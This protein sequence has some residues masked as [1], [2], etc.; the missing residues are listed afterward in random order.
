[1]PGSTL[2]S[3]CQLSPKSDAS[4]LSIRQS[5]QLQRQSSRWLNLSTTLW[6]ISIRGISCSD[7]D[8]YLS[9]LSSF[10]DVMEWKMTGKVND[11]EFTFLYSEWKKH[12]YPQLGSGSDESQP[13]SYV[14]DIQRIRQILLLR[15]ASEEDLSQFIGYVIHESNMTLLNIPI[16]YQMRNSTMRNVSNL[17]LCSDSWLI[18][19][20]SLFFSL[21]VM[22]YGFLQFDDILF[23]CGCLII[24]TFSTD[25]LVKGQYPELVMTNLTATATQLMKDIDCDHQDC[26]HY[27]GISSHITLPTFESYFLRRGI[28]CIALKALIQVLCETHYIISTANL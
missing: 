12:S 5:N 10:L 15:N 6:A 28:G 13:C 14:P 18:L 27:D 19:C 22:G 8:E 2:T 23:F 3:Q 26:N 1:M 16:S 9:G 21:D 20:E 17:E 25:K 7:T 24:G 4:C 11:E